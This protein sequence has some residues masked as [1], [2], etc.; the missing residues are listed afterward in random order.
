MISVTH[1]S[2]PDNCQLL[3]EETLFHTANGYLGVR[4]AFEEGNPGTSIRGSYINGVYD[5]TPMLQAEP[6]HGLVDKKQTIVN[7]REVQDIK[8]YADGELCTPVSGYTRTLDIKKGIASRVFTYKTGKGKE[9]SLSYQRLCSFTRP[10]LFLLLITL[11]SKEGLDVEITA[12]HGAEVKNFSDPSDPRVAAESR[13]YIVDVETSYK[14][15]V[16]LI[17]SSTAASGIKVSSAVKDIVSCLSVRK[18][19][20]KPLGT[21]QSFSFTLKAGENVTFTRFAAFSDSRKAEDTASAALLALSKAVE[22]GAETVLSEQ[23]EYLEEFFSRFAFSIKG[24]KHLEKAIYFN[25]FELLSSAG[26]DGISHL[27]AKGLSG[28]GYEGH[29]FWDTEMYVEPFFSLV[30]PSISRKL[31]SYRYSKLG[32]AKENAR[33]LGH[34]KGALYPWR[35]ISGEECSGYFPSGTA[36]YH[37]NGAVAYSVILY[38]IITGDDRFLE[39]E[40]LEIL[41]E[42]ARLWLDTGCYY[43]GTFRINAVTGPDEYTC[44][45]NNNYYTNASAKYDLQHAA[46]YLRQFPGKT[47]ELGV[48]EEEIEA[49]EEAAAKM[50]LVYDADLDITPQDDSFLSKKVWDLEATPKEDFPLLLHYHPLTLYRYQVCKQADAVLAHLLYEDEVAPST[51]LSSYRYYSKITTHDSSLSRCI[52]AAVAARLGLTDEAYE[53]FKDSAFIDI[54]NKHGNTKDGIH[55]ANMGGSLMALLYGF[56]GIRVKDDGLYLSPAIPEEWEEL[57][58]SIYVRGVRLDVTVTAEGTEVKA[59]GEP[60]LPVYLDGNRIL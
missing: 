44:M 26:K 58:F 23:Q 42:I 30:S 57:S 24:D 31:I 41:S 52:F 25:A 54:D 60:G 47:K 28:E 27:A 13:Q 11:S 22:D 6:L 3:F 2:L 1:A 55:T 48:T 32:K 29:Y 16:S 59:D 20:Q 49:F 14:D 45:V 37:I 56:A 4:G 40:G 33:L 7:L 17:T 15:G 34:A 46:K 18:V 36:Q 39:E 8:V 19:S 43:K 35:T 50:Y 21:R 10:E 12:G 38:Y 5:I 9:L 53:H 51:I